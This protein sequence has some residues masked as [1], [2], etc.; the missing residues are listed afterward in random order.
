MAWIQMRDFWTFR[1][2]EVQ[3]NKRHLFE[4]KDSKSDTGS[5]LLVHVAASHSGIVSGNRRFY[6][7]DRMQE[8]IHTWLPQKAKDGT[9]LR[10][11]RPVLVGHD[12]KGDVLG[13]VLEAKY[14]DDSWKYA[15]DFPVV[16]D[17]LFYQRD[18]RKRQDLYKSVDWVVDNLLPLEEYT[19]LGYTEL[20]IRIT[21]PEAIR[22]VLADEYLTVSVGFKTDQAICSLCHT[23]WATDG[24]CGHKLGEV[25][26][27]KHMFLIAGAME[28]QELSFINFAADPFA[29]VLDKKILTDSFEKMFFLGLPINQQ[30]SFTADGLQLTD[31]LIFEDQAVG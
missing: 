16:K 25:D 5:S 9:M 29:T 28:N 31:G 8:S 2:T 23:N 12:E 6:R 18:G 14:I 21:N 10:T 3:E 22:K 20:G 4:C 11:A 24:K 17:F 19:G 1:P 30:D 7:P 26:E 15:A 27:G 13:R